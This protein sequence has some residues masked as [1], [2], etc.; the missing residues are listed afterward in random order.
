MLASARES[1]FRSQPHMAINA[2]TASAI[3]IR[4]GHGSVSGLRRNARRVGGEGLFRIL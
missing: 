4:V 1:A 3:A 2:M